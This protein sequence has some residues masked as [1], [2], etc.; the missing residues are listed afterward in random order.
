VDT[1]DAAPLYRLALE[2]A[3]AGTRLHGV[4][5]EGVVS[6]DRRGHVDEVTAEVVATLTAKLH[7]TRGN[8]RDDD[9]ELTTL[10]AKYVKNILQTLR[11]VLRWAEEMGWTLKIPKVR[12]PRI[13][14]EEVT[15]SS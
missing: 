13:D 15:T 1:L 5:D 11:K 12:M 4:A 3:P 8:R 2:S 10:S 7:R 9:G 14:Q 6:R